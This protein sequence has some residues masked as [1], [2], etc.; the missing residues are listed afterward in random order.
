MCP[1][2]L[3]S[4]EYV[5]TTGSSTNAPQKTPIPDKVQDHLARSTVFSMLD[6][7]S[8]YWQLSV[9]PADRDKTAFCPGPGLGFYEFCRMPFGLSGTPSSF[10]CLMDKTLH[11]LS[12]V[13]I[14]LDDI[15]LKN[16]ETHTI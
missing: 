13:T 15:L 6:L 4:Y 3:G 16:E 10:Q 14:Y 1:R 12:F 7:H 11:G 5:L 8:G 2:N 9:N